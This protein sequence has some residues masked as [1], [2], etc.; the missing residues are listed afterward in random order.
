MS[1][2]SIIEQ[3]NKTVAFLKAQDFA[4]AVIASSSALTSHY[5]LENSRNAVGGKS[6]GG[7]SLDKCML[8]SEVDDNE[9]MEDTDTTFIYKHGILL[10]PS[11]TEFNSI[12]SI[13]VFNTALAHHLA[14]ETN[15]HSSTAT[16]TM[17][18]RARRLYELAYDSQKL[19][20]NLLFQFAVIN[21][22]AVVEQ[23]IANNTTLSPQCFEYLMSVLMV[24]VDRGCVMRLRH[25]RGFLHNVI[26]TTEVA[27]A[28]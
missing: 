6:A 13:L 28:A 18:H 4:S 23:R 3:N 5:A 24:L 25:V 12:T 20:S 8:L 27:A 19:D 16:G 22:I 17:L 26:L 15:C 7:C 2:T 10:H 14:A 11:V 21:N 1:C 9:T